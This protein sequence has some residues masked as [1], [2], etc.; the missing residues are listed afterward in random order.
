MTS[1][2]RICLGY[3]MFA[4]LSSG[5]TARQPSGHAA[6]TP[7]AAKPADTAVWSYEERVGVVSAGTERACFTTKASSL[8]ANTPLLV[9]DPNTR[10]RH[11]AVILGADAECIDPGGGA[12]G[13]HGY[14]IRL[15]GPAPPPFHA[16]GVVNA[17][18]QLR[19]VDGAMAADVDGDGRD[20]FFRACTSTEGL[21]FTIWTGAALTSQRRWHQYQYLG[22]DVSPTCTP[23]ESQ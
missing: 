2:L 13:L 21:H 23:A 14:A 17:S 20:E 12:E 15:E 1:M 5:C 19:A 4:M 11:R 10:Q 9:V 7:A 22:Y 3:V 16:I 6:G 8:A 18:A